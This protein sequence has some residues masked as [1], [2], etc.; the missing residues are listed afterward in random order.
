[1][2]TFGDEIMTVNANTSVFGQWNYTLDSFEDSIELGDVG[3]G[4]FE[5]YAT[6]SKETEERLFFAINA[7]L[8][9]GG[10][11]DYGR[12]FGAINW[13]DFILN[14]SDSNLPQATSD[15][16]YGIHFVT[17]E[18]GIT[19][20][21][22]YG[23]VTVGSVTENNDQPSENIGAYLDLINSDEPR[24][25]GD[26]GSDPSYF[27]P[28]KLVDNVIQTGE[29]LGGVEIHAD[30]DES[31]S[32]L[33][34]NTL[35]ATGTYTF[36]FSIDKSLLP[37]GNFT[38]HLAPECGNDIVAIQGL[39][40][41]NPALEIEKRTNG[42][43]ADTP[44]LAV[45]IAPGETVTWSYEVTNTGDIAVAGE[46]ISVTDD[47]N[48]IPVLDTTTDV[49]SDNILSPGETWIYTATAPAEDF[50]VVLDFETD[51][52]G[53]P[54]AA[55]TTI[56]DE[57]Q[58][59]GLT[60][61]TPGS[62]FG[63]MI[64]DSNNPV[65]DEDLGTPNED[66]DGPG[67]G[68][69]GGQGEPGENAQALDNILIISEDGNP[70]RPNDRGDGGIL[71]FDWDAPV[72]V[73]YIDILD[74]SEEGTITTYDA[75]NQPIA[76]Y[77]IEA[78]ERNGLQRVTLGGE[79]ATRIEVDFGD[80]A[81]VTEL[82]YDRIYQNTGT[83]IGPGSSTDSDDSHYRPS[84]PAIDIEKKTNGIDGDTIDSAVRV[85]PGETVTWT[86][87][88]TNTGNIAFNFEDVVVTDDQGILPVFD[89]T[90]DFLSDGILSPG[91][92][93]LYSATDVA[94]DLR[95]NIDFETDGAGNPLAAGTTIDF[96]Y[97]DWGL[98]V[99]TPVSE[100]GAMI[101]D[102]SNPTGGDW[103]LKTPGEGNNEAL[104]NILIISEDG[105]SD[106]PDDN[107]DGG[108]LR[109]EWD[110]PVRLYQVG[111][112]D[113]E[114]DGVLVKTYNAAG[115]ELEIY[116]V[117]NKGNN[118][119]QTIALDDELV[120]SMEVH[121]VT[122]GAVTDLSWEH[123]YQNLGTVSINGFEDITDSDLSHYLNGSEALLG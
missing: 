19:D 56:D 101:F 58:D 67:Q 61:S 14:F 37:E 100:H 102:S 113:I 87:A 18:A 76:S 72:N 35:G 119:F 75:N 70:D 88:V 107:A 12:G 8:P 36:G 111:L 34:F 10:D 9:L 53:N 80:S 41:A 3:G 26:L 74:A 11:P 63:A 44:D 71:K 48:L 86:Y 66:F 121:L 31:L 46:D 17:N 55:G 64:F 97:Q 15:S 117:P 24:I 99:S 118:S 98:T 82:A 112:L 95:V 68:N 33:T 81:A 65:A 62:E 73:Y 23:G 43:D 110:D 7:N 94:E 27:D 69:G 57:Y 105:D 108:I 92:T 49:N 20:L 120:A 45:P 40:N 83:V 59:L 50:S 90:S 89:A 114:E 93:W 1:L 16:L 54:L 51:G 96:E 25:F 6:A 13:G 78:L 104:D 84:L 5:I 39:V 79:L 30:G 52:A 28:N 103:D 22:L 91:E 123:P 38:A 32:G 42:V 2:H 21:G 106:D 115:D 60:I 109:F 116:E 77:T 122:S 47:Q 85:Q 29:R 4:G